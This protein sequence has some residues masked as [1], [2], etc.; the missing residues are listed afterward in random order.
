L[1]PFYIHVFF[2]NLDSESERTYVI[3]VFLSVAYFA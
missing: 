1:L 3:F 2:K